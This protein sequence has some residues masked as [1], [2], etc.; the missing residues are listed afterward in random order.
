M[1]EQDF[2]NQ[3]LAEFRDYNSVPIDCRMLSEAL[4][5]AK[6]FLEDSVTISEGEVVIIRTRDLR[7]SLVAMDAAILL[8]AE[9]YQRPYKGS[10]KTDRRLSLRALWSVLKA[11]EGR[12][13]STMGLPRMLRKSVQTHLDKQFGDASFM[14]T[15]FDSYWISPHYDD[16]DTLLEYLTWQCWRAQATKQ[17]SVDRSKWNCCVM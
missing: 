16:F 3:S 10:D 13:Y 2:L 17:P 8:R 14:P 4:I 6:R 9:K 12:M 1:N 5:E 7:F 11:M 15:L